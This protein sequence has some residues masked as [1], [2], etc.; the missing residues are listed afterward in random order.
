MDQ[1]ERNHAAHRENFK[2]TFDLAGEYA[3]WIL[4]TLLLLNS[5]A[6]AGI[7]QKDLSHAYGVS[8]Y[9][10]AAG[11]ISALI[12]GI[13]GWFNL[14]GAAVWYHSAAT[15]VLAGKDEH[16]RPKSIDRNRKYALLAAFSSIGCLGLGTPLIAWALR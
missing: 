3:K 15:A 13:A 10:F 7:F 6:I 11:V 14:Q 2:I 12:S 4:S 1:L 16:A 5:G 9:F 8:L